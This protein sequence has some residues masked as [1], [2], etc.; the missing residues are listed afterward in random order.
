MPESKVRKSVRS[1]S[2]R[3]RGDAVASGRPPGNR[4]WVPPVFIAV[5]LL[6]VIW[7]VLYYIAGTRVPLIKDLGDWNILIGM[8]LMASSFVIATL[9]R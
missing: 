5:G 9:W 4:Q 3:E 2:K 1:R 7:L 6:G 8:G